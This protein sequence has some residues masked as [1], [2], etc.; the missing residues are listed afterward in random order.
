MSPG[1]TGEFF[2]RADEPA[3]VGRKSREQLLSELEVLE[4]QFEASREARQ[5]LT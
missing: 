1:D 2:V 4:V 5:V 3:K